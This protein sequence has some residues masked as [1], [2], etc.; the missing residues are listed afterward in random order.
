MRYTEADVSSELLDQPLFAKEPKKLFI[1]STARSGSYLLCRYMINTGLGVPHEYFNPIIMRQIAPRLGLGAAIEKLQWPPRNLRDRLPFATAARRQE[2][3]FLGK[4]LAAL[5]P[6]RCQNGIFA[7]KVHF[8][9]FIKVLDNPTGRKLLRDGV[10]IHLYREDL[11]SQAISAH[12]CTLTGRWGIDATVSTAPIANPD[13]LDVRTLDRIVQGLAEQDMGW[14]LFLARNGLSPL[15][16]SYEKLCEDPVGFMITIARQLGLDPAALRH[17][18]DEAI[19]AQRKA[20]ATLP[21][22]REV[23]RSYS[24]EFGTLRKPSMLLPQSPRLTARFGL[25]WAGK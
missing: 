11:L 12:Y 20:D 10:F 22:R 18:Y 9:H 3:A 5:L 15:S 21:C 4:Y 16:I 6:L 24:S 2:E 17:G 14:R 25:Q 19:S 13:F 7:A 23:A 8:E 1:C